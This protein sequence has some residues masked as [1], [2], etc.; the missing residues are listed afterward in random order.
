MENVVT[1][2]IITGVCP[3]ESTAIKL[4]HE[5]QDEASFKPQSLL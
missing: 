5:T 2:F 1:S 4:P 3:F